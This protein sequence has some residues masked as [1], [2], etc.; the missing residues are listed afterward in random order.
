MGIT[1]LILVFLAV[2][3][4]VTLARRISQPRTGNRRG[5]AKVPAAAEKMVR[6]HQCGTYL[7]LSEALF[8]NDH[9]YCNSEHERADETRS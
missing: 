3:L 8:S 7:P 2:W 9:Y 1:R 5:S 6:C 4:L